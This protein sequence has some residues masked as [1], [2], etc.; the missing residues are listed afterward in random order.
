MAAKNAITLD[1]MQVAR[2][3]SKV[4]AATD[5]QCWDWTGTKN[6]KGYG[7]VM[8]RKKFYAAHRIAYELVNG[9]IPE[10]SLIRH[11]CDNPACCNPRHLLPGTC[12][13]NM[14]DA[15]TRK[16]MA[17]GERSGRTRLT[18][19]DVAYIR[20]NPER[21]TQVELAARYGMAESSISYIRSGRS[22]KMVGDDGVEPSTSAM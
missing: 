22:W 16:R 8:R 6:A 9:P 1:A 19:A 5:F 7:R 18:V 12:Q 14:D 2:F 10:A 11:T 21:V 3:W 20:E 13:Q 15:V 17:C 4:K